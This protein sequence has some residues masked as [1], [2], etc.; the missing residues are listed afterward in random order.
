MTSEYL[1]ASAVRRSFDR[2]S[3]SYDAAA[4]LQ[5][6]V[7]EEL[8]A[9]L[10][11]TQLTPKVILDAGAG[12][13]QA[14]RTL[15]SRYPEATVVAVDNALGMLRAADSTEANSARFERVC[16]DSAVLPLADASVDLIFSNLML[17]WCDPMA[18]FAEFRRVLA[19]R[20][21]LS[22]STFGPDTL[23][24]L[25]TAWAEVDDFEHV[26]PFYDMHDLGDALVHAGLVQPVLDV[27]YYTLEYREV[28]DLARDLKAIGAH[29]ASAG[30]RRGL[31]TPRRFAAMQAAY[32]PFRRNDRLPATYEVIYGQAWAPLATREREDIA[33]FSVDDLRRQLRERGR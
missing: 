12:T 14:S 29:D 24:E 33:T 22:F 8:L 25:R 1:N 21:A 23:Q 4:V 19:P 3:A 31:T 6:Q 26:S 30:R 28:R 7:R 13:S 11:F 20:G 2:A 15:A 10:E 5:T 18:V 16:A 9:R 32:E 27:D 17:Q